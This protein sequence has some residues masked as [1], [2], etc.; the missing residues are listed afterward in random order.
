MIELNEVTA[1]LAL[2]RHGETKAWEPFDRFAQLDAVPR[3][4]DV[5][6]DEFI[7]LR[8]SSLIAL[9]EL[10]LTPVDSGAVARLPSVLGGGA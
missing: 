9:A 5:L 4:L 1:L 6:L 2:L 8:R 3:P 7:G 10:R